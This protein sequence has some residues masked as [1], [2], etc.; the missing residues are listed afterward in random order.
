[1]SMM[2]SQIARLRIVYSSVY[3]GADQRKQ[4]SSSGDVENISIWNHE[5]VIFSESQNFY[6]AN[7]KS[8]NTSSE[9][10]MFGCKMT[11]IAKYIVGS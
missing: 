5:L 8:A 6:F 4:Q 9:M 2:A 11:Y 7:R 1:M 10:Q 3:S